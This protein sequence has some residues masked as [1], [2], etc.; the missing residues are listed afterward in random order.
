MLLFYISYAKSQVELQS[1]HID[2]SYIGLKLL[3]IF[4]YGVLN[5]LNAGQLALTRA[6]TP[7]EHA[8]DG[9]A[10]EDDDYDFVTC[11]RSMAQQ[12]A[13]ITVLILVFDFVSTFYGYTV[14]SK[15]MALLLGKI[16][17]TLAVSALFIVDPNGR[18]HTVFTNLDKVQPTRQQ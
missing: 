1:Y 10:A 15:E 16:T 5:L 12:L 3:A 6:P 2:R 4:I 9:I 14:L 7:P 18:L 8:T 17:T 11:T 13:F